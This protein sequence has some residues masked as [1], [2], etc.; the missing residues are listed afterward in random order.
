MSV[1][2]IA[3]L[4]ADGKIS[5]TEVLEELRKRAAIPLSEGQ[6]GLW[7]LHK[8]EPDTYAYNVP[9]CFSCDNVDA[10][11]LE[12]AFRDTL[13]QHSLLSATVSETD[14]GPYLTPCDPE[15][16]AVEQLD[17]ASKDDVVEY[18]KRRAREPFDPVGGPL[19]R[20]SILRCGDSR[21]YVLLTVHHL[22][23]DGVS[24][25]LVLDTLFGAYQ[26][27]LSGQRPPFHTGSGSFGEF[28]EWEQQALAGT[29]GEQ[30][31]EF[32]RRELAGATALTGLPLQATL[33]PDA[34]HDGAVHTRRL[35]RELADTAAAYSEA[36]QIGLASFYLATFTTLLHRYTGSEDIVLGM[37][38]S[39]RPMGRFDDVVGYFVNTLPVRSRPSGAEEFTTF[40]RA[41]QSTVFEALD[42]VAYPFHR[43]VRDLGG[44][45][46]NLRSPVYNVVFN[47][48]DSALA[49]YLSG[50]PD[51]RGF[52][53]IEDLHQLGE[54]DLTLDVAPGDGILLTFKYHPDAFPADAVERMAEHF[55]TLI[56]DI[57]ATDGRSA[58]ANLKLLPQAELRLVTEEW[59]RT[60]AGYPADKTCWDLFADQAQQNPDAPAATCGD[61]TLT[62]RELADRCSALAEVLSGQGIAAG[63][64]VG[65]CFERS[66]DLLVGLLAVMKLGAAYVP[67]DAALPAERLSYMIQDSGAELVVCHDAVR[68][69]LAAVQTGEA[70]LYFI[71]G[72]TQHPDTRGSST[73][74][75]TNPSSTALAYVIYTSGSTGK[76]KGVA[77]PHTALT[78]FLLA[79]AQTLSVTARDRLLA[80]TTHSFDIAALELYLPLVTGGH[81]NICDAATAAD[82][83]LLADK[84]AEWRPTVVQA[85]PATWI[86]LLRVGWQNAENIKIL[87]GG[88]A[89]PAA[90]KD[91]LV[92]LG[93]TWNLYGPTETTIWS[94]AKRL[95]GDG[96]VS[97]GRPIANTQVYVLDTGMAPTPI[98]VPGELYIAGDGVALGYHGK[99]ELTAQRFLDNPFAPGRRL[100]R[101]GDLAYW[102]PHGEITLLGRLDTQIKLRGYRIELGEIEAVL[103]SH[104][105][106]SRAVVVVEQ[107]GRS[108]RLTAYYT[109]NADSPTAD[110]ALLRAHLAKTLPAY[111][112]PAAFVSV[113]E[114]PLTAN[115]KVDRAKLSQAAAADAAS[116]AA[117]MPGKGISA[118]V[119]I[120]RAV[121]RIFAEVLGTRDIERDA[122]FFDIGG[123]SFAAIEVVAAINT[124]FG[125]TLRPTSLFAHASVASMAEYLSELTGKAREQP[126]TRPRQRPRQNLDFRPAR[127]AA[128]DDDHL[129]TAIAVIGMSCRFPGADE[130]SAFWRLLIEG[131]SGGTTW[132][133]E[134]LRGLGVPEE[135]ITRAGYVPARSVVTG[136]A[137]FD[138]A[139]FGI[140]P[141]D[142]E[143]MDPQ[144]RLLLQHSWQALEDAGYRPEDVP[145]TSVFT[146]ASTNFYQALLP[147]L[148]ANASGARVLADP[149]VY[150]AWLFA[151]GGTVPTM[152]S[153]KLG[154]RGPSIAVSTNCSSALSA[155]HL[156]CQGLS[157]GDADQALVGAASLFTGGELGY[158]HQPGL[159]FSS[160]GHSRAFA[161]GADGMSGG[162]GVGVVVLKRAREA[163]ADGDHVYCLIRGIAVNNDGGD[164]AGFYA[165]SVRGQ[166]EVIGR[167]LDRAGVDPA[168]IGYVEAHGTGTKLGDPVEVAAL[169]EAYRR[170]TGA[171]GYCGIGS[172]KSNIGHLD[173]AAGIAGLIKAAL[174]LHHGV[175]PRTL[176]AEVPSGEI[177]WEDSP[178]FVA[179][180]NLPLDGPEPARVGL[181][182][183]GIGGTN[184]HAVLEQAPQPAPVPRIPG[185]HAVVL[186]ARDGERLS[187]LARQL[188]DFLPGYRD[189]GGDLSSLAYTLQVGRRAMTERVV[190]VAEDLDGLIAQVQDYAE[191]GAGSSAF[192]GSARRS[193]DDLVG[194]FTRA[195][196]LNDVVGQWL[197]DG[198]WGKVAPL[199]VNGV[200]VDWRGFHGDEPPARVSLPTYQFA[201]KRYWPTATPRTIGHSTDADGGMD[202]ALR[203]VVLAQLQ[204]I[205]LFREPVRRDRIDAAGVIE[206]SHALWLD[207]TVTVLLEAGELVQRDGLLVPR[208]G[209]SG[210]DQAWRGWREWRNAHAGDAERAAKAN[211]LDPML[212]AL[213]TILTGQSQA[214]AAMFPGGTFELVG[215]VYRGNATADYFNTV[216]AKAVRAE[217]EARPAGGIRILEVGAGT[218]S[219]SEQV[220]AQVA[221][222]DIAEYCYTDIS[223]AFLIEAEQ[224]F[225]DRVP[226]VRFAT[227]NAEREPGEQ[228]LKAGT[229]DIVVANN[230]LHA[231]Q[232]IVQTVRH[233]RSLLR[234]GGILV[235]NELARN[236][237][238]AHLTFGL[239]DGW[240][241]ATDGRRLAGGPALSD[242]AWREVLRECGFGTVEQL[243]EQAQARGQQVLVARAASLSVKAGDGQI[244]AAVERILVEAL[245]LTRD[246][247]DADK[248]FADY[249]V[250]SLTGVGMVTKLNESLGTDLDPSV[251]FE[252]PS[253]R[254]LAKFIVHE[255]GAVV[256]EVHEAAPNVS[257]PAVSV[258]EVIPAGR[259]PIAIIGMSGR[260]PAA[261][262]VEEFW[263]LLASGRDPVAKVTRWD[264][265]SLGSVCVDGGLMDGVEEFDPLFF[266][267]SGAEATYMEPQQRLFLQEAW[268][269]LE[270]A[271]HAGE[272]LDRDR[273]GVYVGC[274]AGDYL[275]LTGASDY[276]GQAF[277]GNMNSLVP[278]RIA[279]YLD[280]HGPAM[281]VDTACS[282]SLVSLYLACQGLW[283]GEVGTAIAGGVYVQ[284]SPRLYLAASRAGMLSPTGRCRTFD[285]AADGFVPAEGVGALVLKRLSDAQ[286]DGDHVHGV[287]SGIGINQNGTTNGIVAPN[288]TAQEQLIRQIY[289]DFGIDPAGI[290]LVETHGT[291]TRLGDP[292]EFRALDRAFRS[293]TG[294][295]GFA[296]LG[297]VKAAV[298]H[299]QA[300]AG[301][302]GVIKALLAI[303]HETIPG[304]PHH[305]QT[306]ASVTLAG[307][308][309][310]VHTGPRPWDAPADG[311]RR[312]A[313]TS[314]GASGT[315][316]HAVIEQA[317]APTP[318]LHTRRGGPWLIALSAATDRALREQVERLARHCRLHPGLD[319]GDA[320]YTLLLGRRHL[321]H[322]WAVVVRDM[323]ELELRLS[324]QQLT[325]GADPGLLEQR[326]AEE[327]LAG[328]V[329]DFA[330]L[331]SDSGYRRVPLPGYAFEREVYS[332][333]R[334][335]AVEPPTRRDILTGDEFYLREHRVQGTAI[336]PGAM[337]LNWAAERAASLTDVVFLRPLTISSGPQPLKV[338]VH[339]D[340]GA[341]RFEV[342]TGGEVHCQ[343]EVSAVEPRAHSLD[344]PTLLRGFQ[345]T[346]FDADRFYTEWRERGIDYGP[347]F[348]GVV[349]VHQNDDGAVLA[350]LRLPDIVADSLKDFTLH[351]SLVDSAMQCMRFLDDGGQ[352]GLV[353]TIKSVEVLAPC[354]ATMWAWVR[355]ADQGADRIDIDLLGEDG[356][357]CLRLRGIAGR[358]TA[359]TNTPPT[360][361]SIAAPE[362]P[363]S[364]AVTLL[365]TWDPILEPHT[366]AWPDT[367]ESVGIIATSF[368]AREVL[369]AQYPAARLLSADAIASAPDL[370][371]LIWVAP[372]DSG[373][374]IIDGQSI[375][376]LQAFRIIKALLTAGYGD[377]PLG[378]TLITRRA[379]A[380]YASEPVDPTHAG[381]AGLAGAVA[382]EYPNWRV[383]VADL[384]D[385]DRRSLSAVLSLPANP[386]GDLRLRRDRRWHRQQLMTVRADRP[387]TSRLRQG[388][389]YVILGGAG[390]LGT[391]ISEYLIR[392]YRAQVV[393]LGRRPADETIQAAIA[394]AADSSGPAPL[395]LRTDA[396]DAESLRAAKVEIVRRF[397]EVHGVI[398]SGLVFA[399][400][401]L[402]RMTEA[403]FE[404]VLRG[405]VDTS[406]RLLD[407][408]ADQPLDFALFL[409]SINSYLKAI[410][411]ANYA[412]ACTFVDSFARTARQ[413]TGI[414]GKVLNLGYCFNNTGSDLPLIQPEELTAA[415]ELLCASPADQLTLMKFGPALNS[416]G[417][418][419]GD[420]E[421]LLPSALPPEP[422]PL[423]TTTALP[424]LDRLRARTAELTALAI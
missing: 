412:A 351:P 355:R 184:V 4:Y 137:D 395:Y 177:D 23:I 148:M 79:M 281:A 360:A 136:R 413:R 83:T 296:S 321:R 62:Y 405:K 218:G 348:Q 107:A 328:G 7:A 330:T 393:W 126:G 76:P 233:V 64:V 211:L 249:G 220:F 145:A 392:R 11:A 2:T 337:F 172:V 40:A 192:T 131:R 163:I 372:E 419:V 389:T 71:D 114:F 190:F 100:Y 320:S 18:L 90:L 400:A 301:V 133:P 85:T 157:A 387:P 223:K 6:R 322:R 245:K 295:Q 366:G 402:A 230:V 52:Q 292:V 264:L 174:A 270:D 182:S 53:L 27:R 65:V 241:R 248:P 353:F 293:F 318:A 200:D 187:I 373:K 243:A 240:W 89:L 256:E 416:R 166:A 420:D 302:I 193:D 10:H 378:L 158:V 99:P 74:A 242:R 303:R 169:A 365:P 175:V 232:D 273:C 142:A 34:P 267:I 15:A 409:S 312:A 112:I 125:L 421:V 307:S 238:W 227:L 72:Q 244:R 299:A 101:T 251:L 48:Q 28:V 345:P 406:A 188:L 379:H 278:S 424:D 81:V 69:R 404:D 129:D 35:P 111:M 132:S 341:A 180:E 314:L 407:A 269:A 167:A 138:A 363:P 14:D 176:H 343:G 268:R 196:E 285:Q 12:T 305:Q 221:G 185:P 252:N 19:A 78:N 141:R 217:V 327:F 335:T 25:P 155:L 31:R 375:G 103:D 418:T 332:L 75:E 21:S 364:P 237:W 161:D 352:V 357:A 231:T 334:R 50:R 376:T 290:G 361:T 326:L 266:G 258:P 294:E 84:I 383:R 45:G 67:L 408:F 417:I 310:Y 203:R 298:G 117:H 207:H 36:H 362:A 384:D 239:L 385:Y 263:E 54:Y 46:T 342:S 171:T 170:T 253:I 276:P 283:S 346:P 87:C 215:P 254:R 287:I 386:D 368:A 105:G 229:Y 325:A 415:I 80:V 354:T 271:G 128:A 286:A 143:L 388:G 139:F 208:D 279:Y 13:A 356:T 162:E 17:V 119:G 311:R 209:V 94:T 95:S 381:V 183:F 156:A 306:N 275:D 308:P 56:G 154:L 164:K 319:L 359:T 272:S 70:R 284:N 280:L 147:G 93:Q 382:K 178:F 235:L 304:L 181:S 374:D 226:Y 309:F 347:A 140:S 214:T 146:A 135:L 186:S 189:S 77:V 91:Q 102:S 16:F 339:E 297:S 39:A 195:G 324:A 199:W 246:E 277:W 47:Y 261:R 26:A 250:D 282:S 323:Q 274:A 57:V 338:S 377:R 97:I 403:Q 329:P 121:R 396:T 44:R 262:D 20:L 390:G 168:T 66:L 219:T 24:G 43:I 73:A 116:A 160:D 3:R 205:G 317:P 108:E 255:G 8:M 423:L 411:Q 127:T 401:S 344:M 58:L 225:A 104:P 123:D 422:G 38:M 291:G 236:E 333:P 124:A 210:L 300:A 315:N 340:N 191:H 88:E 51:A 33:P 198:E 5:T 222:H 144:A 331:F 68:D 399:G 63:D 257:A 234:P 41:V 201:G 92:S 247:L 165:P 259:E 202:P 96:P 194:L 106:V 336:A 350:Q 204:A 149:E 212:A 216:T 369:T 153:T 173:A 394:Q 179:G 9:L 213:P 150:A 260:F 32:W 316:A 151:Q 313:V 349:A 22:V 59:N 367:S 414:A 55:I 118:D 29:D 288:G 134:E 120:E 1:R 86:M 380:A 410:K 130:L 49:G 289:T 37:P 113:P 122:G 61:L 391:A 60:Q 98:G 115:G 110:T 397:G 206:P 30:D 398:H 228:G 42:H 197:A 109:G 370:D 265:S 152:I 358:R 159:N 82:A 224:R 371:H